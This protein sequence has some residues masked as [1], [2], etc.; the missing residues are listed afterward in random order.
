MAEHLPH[1][2]TLEPN[3]QFS[4]ISTAAEFLFR[5]RVIANRPPNI[6][7][8]DI[9]KTVVIVPQC[10]FLDQLLQRVLLGLF[11]PTRLGFQFVGGTLIDRDAFHRIEVT[12]IRCTGSGRKD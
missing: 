5:D 2:V 7:Y 1:G 4:D 9:R 6:F 3:R 11:D 10:Y 12:H 8:I